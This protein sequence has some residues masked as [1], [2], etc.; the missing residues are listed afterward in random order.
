MTVCG[1]KV[2]GICIMGKCP[3]FK[4][5]CPIVWDK[6]PYKSQ[7]NFQRI[8]ASPEALAEFICAEMDCAF[9]VGYGGCDGNKDTLV[10]WLKE[11]HH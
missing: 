9:C 10:K 8:T 1:E 6:Y 4:R 2:S 3:H 11:K 5:C 7:T